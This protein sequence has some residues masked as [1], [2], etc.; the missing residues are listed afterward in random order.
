MAF[1]MDLWEVKD[2]QLVEL[3]KQRLDDEQRLE[4]WIAD[5]VSLLG[6]DVLVI[7]R[8]IR[9]QSGGRID[10]LAIDRQGDLLILELKRDRTPREVVAQ[11]LDYASWVADLL[12]QQIG[13][14]AQAYLGKPLPEAFQEAFE[15]PVPEVINNDHRIVIVASELDDS[16]ERIVQYL[17]TRHSVNINVVFFTCFQQG[18]KELVGRAW[19]LDPEQVEERSEARRSSPWKGQWF[20]NVGENEFRNWDDCIKYGFLAAGWGR[21]YTDR[22]RNYPKTG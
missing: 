22:L 8:Q 15:S 7:G 10:L 21:L 3:S 18:K 11:T 12:P 17:S 4:D 2:G 20:V 13:E 6:L 14:I 19:L 1:N 16:S 9:S 5:N